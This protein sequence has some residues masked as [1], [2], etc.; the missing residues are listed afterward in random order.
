[1]QWRAGQSVQAQVTKTLKLSS[2]DAQ[3]HDKTFVQ[4]CLK[5][6]SST[7]SNN[8]QRFSYLSFC[9]ENYATKDSLTHT[10]QQPSLI[11]HV[12]CN[13]KEPK[14][15]IFRFSPVYWLETIHRDDKIFVRFLDDMME[16]GGKKYGG[17]I[18]KT[19]VLD[20]VHGSNITWLDEVFKV[21][22]F[23]LQFINGNL[24]VLHSAHD[25]GKKETK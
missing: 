22:D 21:A 2:L 9:H 8:L 6:N 3:D 13:K 16:V 12:I 4:R 20:L 23:L 10:K 19:C 14:S 17:Q 24:F 11:F 5:V 18:N 1:M 15:T 7:Q 25:L